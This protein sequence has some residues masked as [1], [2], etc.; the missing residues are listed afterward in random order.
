M[1]E[2]KLQ[3]K[4]GMTLHLPV[5]TLERIDREARKH[6]SSRSRYIQDMILG[7]QVTDGRKKRKERRESVSEPLKEIRVCISREAMDCLDQLA[8][9]RH[10]S[11]ARCAREI[12]QSR[13]VATNVYFKL[14]LAELQPV[15]DDLSIIASSMQELVLR[16]DRTTE[17]KAESRILQKQLLSEIRKIRIRMEEWGDT[18]IGNAQ[19]SFAEGEGLRERSGLSDVSVG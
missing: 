7:V 18:R 16:P 4:L 10:M 15:F 2:T 5:S 12:I 11:R 9:A 14:D 17:E 6:K 19:A 8:G 13:I 1:T 3:P